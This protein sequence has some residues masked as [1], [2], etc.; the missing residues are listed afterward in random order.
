MLMKIICFV[1]PFLI[2]VFFDLDSEILK[3][4]AIWTTSERI[5]T[6]PLGVGIAKGEQSC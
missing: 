2:C 5:R 1:K 6:N 4:S 3:E